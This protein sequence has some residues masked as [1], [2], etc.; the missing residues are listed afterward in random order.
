MRRGIAASALALI[1]ACSLTACG[2]S[3]QAS[4]SSG[5]PAK[6]GGTV[7]WWDT[8]DAKA[9]APTYRAIVAD[10]E[11]KYPKIK[12]NY[13]N[14]PFAD[15]QNRISTAFS[16]GSDAPDVIRSEVGW[17]PELAAQH[18]LRP[19]DGTPALVGAKDFLP[20]PA[21]A[22][23]YEGKTYAVPQVTDTMA[24]FYNKRMFA[25]AGIDHPP[26]TV[27]ELETDSALIK[28]KLG[29]TG[30]YLRGDDAYWTLPFIYGEGGDLVDADTKTVTVDNAAGIRA[31]KV[32]KGL[33]DSGAAKT[34]LTDGWTKMMSDFQ[35]GDVAMMING[36]W[37]LSTVRK[38]GGAFAAPSNLGIAVV[39][40]G[41]AG[42]GAP[43]GG[44]SYAVYAN[45][46]NIAAS[47]LFVQYM[48]SSEVQAKITK[49]LGVL[50][51]RKSVWARPDIASIDSVKSFK[52]AIDKVHQ[53]PWIPEGDSLFAPLA[54]EY[55]ALLS[56]KE[57]PQSAARNTGDAYRKNL[58]WK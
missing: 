21:A 43:Q 20:N 53:R 19:L 7:T 55:A 50:P 30:F 57:S 3:D 47:E 41:S 42:Q 15:A 13:V 11:A 17:T 6:D 31:F 23:R 12:V 1:L 49:A 33:V 38:G 58:G 16:T 54:T 10:F 2:G 37:A 29:K 35:A 51:T 48:S 28:K 24:L 22:T 34:S 39:P 36:P 52:K 8:S 45:S 27:D 46:K 18:Y 32:I 56:G 5:N 14:V 9:E 26:V 4:G 40:A 44:Q 25:A